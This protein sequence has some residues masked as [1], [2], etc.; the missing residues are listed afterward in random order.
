MFFRRLDREAGAVVAV[1]SVILIAVHIDLFF[2][3]KFVLRFGG[4][5]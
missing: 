2:L 4:L 5:V 3:T 1:C